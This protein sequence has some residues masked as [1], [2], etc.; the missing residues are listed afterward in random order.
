MKKLSDIQTEKTENFYLQAI[1]VY[2]E[3]TTES[4]QNNPH[5]GLAISQ[6]TTK[7]I[8]FY[9]LPVRNQKVEF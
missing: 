5:I 9:S 4:I 3:N 2:I 8:V 6:D 7:T 1:I